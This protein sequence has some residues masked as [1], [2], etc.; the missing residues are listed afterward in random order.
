MAETNKG[1]FQ[2]IIRADVPPGP[3]VIRLFNNE[4]ASA[5]RIVMAGVLPEITETEP[6]GRLDEANTVT[7]LPVTLHG[8]FERGGDSDTFAVQLKAGRTFTA[9]LDGYGLGAPM[10]AVL[11]LVDTNGTRI[12]FNHDHWNLDPFLHFT[13]SANGLFYLR[14]MAFAHPAASNVGFTG[15]Q[16]CIYRLRISQD[17]T[18]LWQLPL[19]WNGGAPYSFTGWNGAGGEFPFQHFRTNISP[20]FALAYAP[21]TREV[22]RLATGPGPELLES[23]PNN[24]KPKAQEVSV[25]VGITAQIENDTDVDVFK[26]D[27]KKDTAY[28]ITLWTGNLG[29]PMNAVFTVQDAEGKLSE[30]SNIQDE[31]RDPSMV[32]KAPRDDSFFLRVRD[33]R[34]KGA[35][36]FFYHLSIAPQ[37]PGFELAQDDHS[38]T[39]TAGKTNDLKLKL[40]R[41]QGFKPAV[42]V[43][44]LGLPE[45]VALADHE[46]AAEKNETTVKLVVPTEAKP[47]SGPVRLQATSLAAE[48]AESLTRHATYSLRFKDE[49]GGGFVWVDQ[50]DQFWLT[51]LPAP[52]P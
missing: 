24:T 8:R 12:A 5:P 22:V 48:G 45:G 29:F 20:A 50:I 26:F 41:L 23:E 13:P 7:N 21:H 2:M 32:W 28:T 15:G 18:I 39:I 4:G 42:K 14:V 34:D 30:Q 46:F 27:A 44:F 11:H 9:R 49:E 25:P 40:Q 10:D 17:A 16:S 6:N 43:E 47:F 38:F 33:L 51:V 52:K 3:Y 36:N 35:T 31:Q 37:S 19:G 1:K